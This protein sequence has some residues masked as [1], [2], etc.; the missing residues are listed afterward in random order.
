MLQHALG[1]YLSL[2]SIA[3]PDIDPVIFSVGPFAVRWYGLAYVAGF[4]GAAWVAYRLS[5]RWEVGLTVDDVLNLMLACVAGVVIGSRVFYVVVYGAGY[6]W[7]NPADIV[8]IWD[9]GMA[10]HGGFLGIIAAGLIYAKVRNVPFLT[11]ADLAAVGAPIGFFFGRI[12][13][14]VNGELWGRQT[15]MPWGVVFGGAAGEVARHPSQLYEAFL[16]GLVMFLVLLWLARKPRPQAFFFG[17]FMLMYGVFR[18][19]TEFV[20]EPDV[21][22]GFLFG[23]LTMGQ[24]LSIPLAVGGAAVV[25]WSLARV[26]RSGPPASSTGPDAP[27]T[28][29]PRQE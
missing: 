1:S 18:L 19:A 4:V 20:R 3:F 21:Q 16:E 14:F 29:R 5:R 10:W 24:L 7:D 6:Y 27:G 17:M 2:G 26:R 23:S 15:D 12:A 9:G 22:I 28:S 8:A 13:N 11:L 25:W